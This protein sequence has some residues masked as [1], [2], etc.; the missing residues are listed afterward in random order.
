MGRGRKG[1]K[2]QVETNMRKE[3]N[4]DKEKYQEVPTARC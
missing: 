2:R 3:T 4:Q 1:E